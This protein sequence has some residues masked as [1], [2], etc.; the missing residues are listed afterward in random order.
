MSLL[1]CHDLDVSVADIPVARELN[2]QLR[3]GEFW[4][5]LGSNGIGKTTLLKCM[6]GLLAPDAGT[7][8]IESR[9]MHEMSR[10]EIAQRLGML[11]QHTV[12]L[13]DS[14]ALQIALTGRHPHLK[15]WS[16]EGNQDIILAQAALDAVGLGDFSNREVT[17]LSGG[18]ARRLAFASLVVQDP[19]IMLLDEPT[20]H[21]DLRHQLRIMD[22]ATQLVSGRNKVVVSALHDVNLAARY[23][24]HI[25]MLFGNGQWQ[26][27]ACSEMLNGP[28]LERLYGCKVE[29]VETSHGPRFHPVGRGSEEVSSGSS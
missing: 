16:R 20:N 18:E 28:S 29:A 8:G 22:I 6:A 26:A 23:C 11:Q 5:L 27:G 14:S 10:K 3:E 9:S 15:R 19:E 17:T 24:S 13:F 12:Y 25:L 21:L 2:L 1:S 4:G 7:I